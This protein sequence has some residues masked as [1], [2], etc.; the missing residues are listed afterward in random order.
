MKIKVYYLGDGLRQN[1]VQ[2]RQVPCEFP[3][4]PSNALPLLSA[5]GANNV[6]GTSNAVCLWAEPCNSVQSIFKSSACI[7]FSAFQH[8]LQPIQINGLQNCTTQ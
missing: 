3:T 8:D 4:P 1:L 6:K 7:T 2:E 5:A